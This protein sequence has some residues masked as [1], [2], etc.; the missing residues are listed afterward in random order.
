M[1]L[2]K[3]IDNAIRFS[4]VVLESKSKGGLSA[5]YIKKMIELLSDIRND[6]FS[7]G[8]KGKSKEALDK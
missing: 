3:R 2:K 7:G 5:Q 1:E 8:E 6:Y 4:G